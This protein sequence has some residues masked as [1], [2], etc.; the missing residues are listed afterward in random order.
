MNNL[1]FVDKNNKFYNF[2]FQDVKT[3]WNQL[4]KKVDI[5]RV[6]FTKFNHLDYLWGIDTPSLVYDKLISIINQYQ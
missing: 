4:P 6:N 1:S 3:L 2:F 5:I